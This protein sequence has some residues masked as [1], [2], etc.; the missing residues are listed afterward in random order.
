MTLHLWNTRKLA[1]ELADGGL[2]ERAGMQYM[3]VASLLYAYNI[4]SF[5]GQNAPAIPHLLQVAGCPPV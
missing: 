5:H 1:V 3:L 2:S 4:Q